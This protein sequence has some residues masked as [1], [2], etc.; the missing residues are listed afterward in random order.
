[1]NIHRIQIL[2]RMCK[3]KCNI[4]HIYKKYKHILIIQLSDMRINSA[5][6]CNSDFL[7]YN[8][9]ILTSSQQSLQ[10]KSEKC[11]NNEEPGHSQN[12]TGPK[13]LMIDTFFH[14]ISNIQY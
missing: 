5:R 8:Y 9:I 13:S 7:R 12:Q 2:H 1:M 6:I 10:P 14:D 4:M 11:Q 3:Q